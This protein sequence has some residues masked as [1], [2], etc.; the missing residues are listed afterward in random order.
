MKI[1]L[2]DVRKIIR[3]ELMK[4]IAGSGLPPIANNF[5]QVPA[6]QKG[7]NDL[8][9][10]Y[11]NVLIMQGIVHNNPGAAQMQNAQL[12]QIAGQYDAPAGEAASRFQQKLS[13]F[14]DDTFVEDLRSLTRNQQPVAQ[15]PAAQPKPAT[16][17][18][19]DQRA[20]IAPPRM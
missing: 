19:S 5:Q 11:K 13:E 7:F 2:K 3:E 9:R 20:T 1:S 4:E 14:L 12:D 10:M 8:V 18:R 17:T 16:G 15:Q 6:L